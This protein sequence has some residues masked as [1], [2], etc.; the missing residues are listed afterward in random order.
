MDQDTV[1]ETRQ[2][3]DDGFS[4]ASASEHSGLDSD[5]AEVKKGRRSTRNSAFD[6]PEQNKRRKLLH[7]ASSGGNAGDVDDEG[8][9]LV[10]QN[11]HHKAHEKNSR[12]QIPADF[13]E[14][15][16]AAKKVSTAGEKRQGPKVEDFRFRF[17]EELFHNEGEQGNAQDQGNNLFPSIPKPPSTISAKDRKPKRCGVVYLSSLPPYLKPSA[18][19]NLLL[20]RGFQPIT[21]IFLTPA[22]SSSHAHSASRSRKRQRYSEGWIEFSSHSL[23]RRCAETLNAT[24]I[25]GSKRSFYHDDVW[26]M[27]YLR[28]MR[29]DELMAGIR[30]ERR[31]EEGRRDEERRRVD[32]EA[33]RFLMDV[34]KSKVVEGMRR[35]AGIKAEN[36][37]QGGGQNPVDEDIQDKQMLWKQFEV[38]KKEKRDPRTDL[39]SV[40]GQIF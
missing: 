32:S 39:R 6:Y 28:G 19:R 36:G 26:N 27:K 7:V 31:E 12:F 29:W 1:N 33:K 34:E 11:S 5:E 22:T 21:R 38:V 4:D 37:T 2:Y 14:D 10:H 16:K 13:S 35:K 24:Q 9:L 23:A 15:I 3:L 8:R 17:P 18:L 25:G 20:Q 40:L 30:E